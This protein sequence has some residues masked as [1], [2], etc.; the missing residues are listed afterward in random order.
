[1]T[2][3]KFCNTLPAEVVQTPSLAGGEQESRAAVSAQWTVLVCRGTRGFS[4]VWVPWSAQTPSVMHGCSCITQDHEGALETHLDCPHVLHLALC[5]GV[6]LE[7]RGW[8]SLNGQT[9]SS[10]PPCA[11]LLLGT[12]MTQD[13][14]LPP[15]LPLPNSAGL[16]VAPQHQVFLSYGFIPVDLFWG[17]I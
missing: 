5:A 13:C 6:I 8:L 7:S 16:D 15:S 12:V 11:L 14:F 17:L 4:S 3:M 1:M 2:S 9:C 10:S